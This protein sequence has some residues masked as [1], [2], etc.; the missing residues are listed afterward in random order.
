MKCAI[1]ACRG[2]SYKKHKWTDEYT[3]GTY[4]IGY[5]RLRCK[6]LENIN[7]LNDSS[8]TLQCYAVKS[9]LTIHNKN[10]MYVETCI[11][12]TK[13]AIS[14]IKQEISKQIQAKEK[15]QFDLAS[16]IIECKHIHLFPSTSLSE[17]LKRDD[18]MD[19]KLKYISEATTRHNLF[20]KLK[21]DI[22][23]FIDPRS[24][25]RNALTRVN[26]NINGCINPLTPSMRLK[27][28]S[29]NAT[30]GHIGLLEVLLLY[31]HHSDEL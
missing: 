1:N 24:I 3:R 31:I 22:K 7:N 2:K 8:H 29:S 6:I 30:L 15:Y 26:V 11:R 25:K 18:L 14:C 10:Q 16:D 4:C 19:R 12:S 9:C 20:T 21:F 27:I 13:T 28:T 23:G 17:N 5:W